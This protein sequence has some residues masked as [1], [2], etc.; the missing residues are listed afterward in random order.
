VHVDYYGNFYIHPDSLNLLDP[1][2]RD[3]I[4]DDVDHE[5][6]VVWKDEKGLG[7]DT[8]KCTASPSGIIIQCDGKSFFWP[9]SDEA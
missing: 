3:V 9:Q 6:Q 2:Q 4:K 5:Y 7:M 8:S 1:Q